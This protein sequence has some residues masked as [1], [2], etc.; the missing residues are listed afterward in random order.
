MWKRKGDL[1]FPTTTAIKSEYISTVCWCGKI[2]FAGNF[3]A[4]PGL[5]IGISGFDLGKEVPL[6]GSC[7]PPA[8]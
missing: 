4:D 2:T 5:A 6:R 3:E 1:T 7:D 8:V